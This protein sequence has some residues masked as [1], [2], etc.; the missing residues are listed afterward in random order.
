MKNIV[1]DIDIFN[2][3][4]D[5]IF[6]CDTA[7]TILE[8]NQAAYSRLG[9]E[10]ES[11][12]GISLFQLI[13]MDEN[14]EEEDLFGTVS[15][16][17]LILQGI[18]NSRKVAF[19]DIHQSSFRTLFS[20]TISSGKNA[21]EKSYI[22]CIAHD[23]SSL[24]QAQ[25]SL[26]AERSAQVYGAKLKAL[27][28]MAAGI[29]HEIN[30]PL[31]IISGHCHHLKWAINEDP[32]DRKEVNDMLNSI[33]ET[34][35]RI[36][37]IIKG[38][39]GISRDS[40][41][42]PVETILL[43]DLINQVVELCQSRLKESGVSLQV[44]THNKEA[45]VSARPSEVSQVILNLINNAVD[46]TQGK[47]K[48]WIQIEYELIDQHYTVMVTDCGDGIPPEIAERIMDPFFT[49]KEPGKGT[50]I[51][52]SISAS[53]IEKNGGRL[54]YETEHAYTRFKF[55]LVKK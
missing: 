37:K 52:M 54:W 49:T 1:S 18:V 48:P 12:E 14:D 16:K 31:S 17:S 55:T 45:K 42:D 35:N 24:E 44:L 36:A 10:H 13:Q 46:A 21:T 41:E 5:Y 38:L 43:D 39:R 40:S 3:T 19:K 9:Y 28:E 47:D 11:L 26:E 8:A 4:F 53:L 51:G 50:G 2:E 25:I 15:L 22:I 20:A 6:I 23:I 34:I 27:G 7:G 33:E 32:I 29:A 30:N